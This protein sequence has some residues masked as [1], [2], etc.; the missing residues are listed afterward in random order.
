MIDAHIYPVNDK[1]DRNGQSPASESDFCLEF[2]DKRRANS[3]LAAVTLSCYLKIVGGVRPARCS[4]NSW[5]AQYQSLSGVPRG[6][7]R[8]SQWA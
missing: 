3:T 7:P 5:I 8:F 1:A 4:L 2:L 6:R